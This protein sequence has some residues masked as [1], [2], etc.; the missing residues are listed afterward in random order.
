MSY[1]M[2]WLDDDDRSGEL[3]SL[4]TALRAV[5]ARLRFGPRP[6]DDTSNAIYGQVSVKAG[7]LVIV[8]DNGGGPVDVVLDEEIARGARDALSAALAF[9]HH[10]DR[11]VVPRD[12][13]TPHTAFAAFEGAPHAAAAMSVEKDA[14]PADASR[15]GG[16]DVSLGVVTIP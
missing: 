12:A 4:S 16:G 8:L 13:R 11:P 7:E 14:R 15:E 6:D 3:R 2:R 9:R 10:L 5:L 1:Y